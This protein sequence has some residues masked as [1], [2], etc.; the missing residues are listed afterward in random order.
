VGDGFFLRLLHGAFKELIGFVHIAHGDVDAS[1][2]NL[3]LD[4][5]RAKLVEFF[6]V[7][8]LPL[9]VPFV[10][11][12]LGELAQGLQVHLGVVT[13]FFV[14]LHGLLLLADAAVGI[15]NDEEA[16]SAVGLE[17]EDLAGHLE[18][19]L[20]VAHGQQQLALFDVLAN[21]AL[22]L[23]GERYLLDKGVDGDGLADEV[24]RADFVQQHKTLLLGLAREDDDLDG[25]ER[26]FDLLYQE[27]S[28]LVVEDALDKHQDVA[29]F[30]GNFPDDLEN[31]VLVGHRRDALFRDGKML[32]HRGAHD[33]HENVVRGRDNE[34]S[35]V[36]GDVI[37]DSL[38]VLLKSV[39]QW[40]RHGCSLVLCLKSAVR[41]EFFRA[42]AG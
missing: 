29:P 11:V 12:E 18:R 34:A 41:K 13:G 4:V 33:G 31:A 5:E 39:V 9:G 19:V 3:P 40:G 20:E 35:I 37:D 16:R 22:G 7:L 23:D 21:L 15:A 1:H 42:V 38:L 32:M 6:Q 2:V 36:F 10:L 24:V 25:A 27:P 26:V 30:R 28:V 17:F 14:G 8:E